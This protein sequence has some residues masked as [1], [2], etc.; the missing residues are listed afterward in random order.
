M[1]PPDSRD[2]GGDPRVIHVNL[3][4]SFRGGE[5]QAELLIRAN[6]RAGLRQRAVVRRG[7]PLAQRLKDVH[8]LEVCPIARPFVANL[9]QLRDGLVHAH[10]TRAAQL[11]FI[12][13]C[14]LGTKYLITRR[15]PKRP[16]SNP[17]TAGVYGRAAC[18]VSISTAIL[19]TMRDYLPGGR[20]ERIPSMA[21]GFAASPEAV[22]RVRSGHAG[23]LLVV[24][25]GA[26]VQRHKGQHVIIDAA[27]RIHPS[28]TEIDFLLL[29]EGPDEAALRERAAGLDNVHF[30]GFRDD[31]ADYIAA[32]DIILYPSM[33]EGLGSALLDAMAAGKPIVAS[34]TGGIPEIVGHGDNGLLAQPGDV[35]AIVE[36]LLRLG[37]DPQLRER[38]GARGREIASAYGADAL[39]ARYRELY[40]ELGAD[41]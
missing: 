11:A 37:A 22:E 36:A 40:A 32:A 10:E 21:A 17:F 33:E 4:P 8:E 9:G 16:K 23:R 27:R 3:A 6:A 25:V 5:R 41:T 20:N 18:V 2:T 12:A 34:N 35:E 1:S 38:M 14:V 24:H 30:L 19:G 7:A 29:G 26:L 13:N 15:V 39:A 28:D 31:V